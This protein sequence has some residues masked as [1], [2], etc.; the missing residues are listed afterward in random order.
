[1][2]SQPR[3]TLVAA[4]SSLSL[5]HGAARA[6]DAAV[7]Y[8]VTRGDTCAA[9][10]TR[11]YGDARL[12]DIIHE[13]N[14]GMGPPPHSLKPGRVLILPPKPAVAPDGPDA[15]LT[16]TKNV[17]EVSAPEPRSGKPN[18]PL[19]R[20]NRVGTKE[21]STADV[22]FRDETRLVLG[23]NTLVVILG[24]TQARAARLAAT[25][26][27]LVTGSLRARLSE[28][29]GKGARPRVATDSGAVALKAGEAQVS[30]DEKKTT[31]LAVYAGESALT[32]QRRSVDVADGFGSKAETGR[33]PTPPRPLPDAPAWSA[34]AP[35]LALTES[36]VDLVF[37]FAPA[38]S[39]AGPAAVEWHVQLAR[40]AEFDDL[41]VDTRVPASTRTIEARGAAAG[42]YF[43]RA[44]AIDDDRFEGKWSSVARA[45]V[46][47]LETTPLSGRRTRVA[48]A[49]S[50]VTCGVEG[51]APQEAFEIDRRVA[52]VVSCETAEGE[53]A[54]LALA[55]L[56][57]GRVD[58]AAE[59]V[60][61]AGRPTSLRVRLTDA[62]GSPVEGV[63]VAVEASPPG[64]LVGPF[65]PGGAGVFVAP[66]TLAPG[67]LGG[68]VRLR[69]DGETEVATNTLSLPAAE[70]A[71]P[72]A[73]AA[74][75]HLELTA[76]GRVARVLEQVGVG[77][78]LGARLAMPTRAGDVL[79]GAE[80]IFEAVPPATSE[81]DGLGD[82]RVRADVFGAWLPLGF[83]LGSA[84]SRLAPYVLV[85]PELL[86]T[87]GRV[88][89]ASAEVA[90]R[91]IA[92][93]AGAAAGLELRLDGRSALVF[94]LSGR[95][96]VEIEG[97]TKGPP[98][99]A[100]GAAFSLGYRFRP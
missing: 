80:G 71:A 78:S 83:R 48:V 56:P 18:D 82:T 95:Y 91:S 11:F 23:E 5:A 2:R 6:E 37:A 99:D 72:A 96:M 98:I 27:T 35:G 28:L 57:L 41:V 44:S 68:A 69:V 7:K 29:A 88:G 63:A 54:S 17:V 32:A 10:A 13:A 94:E 52:R 12:V 77:G 58:A 92:S 22:T 53:R 46:A 4:L 47:S 76:A 70:P 34:P 14:P 9:I 65:A 64:M 36:D 59:L 24:D 74:A 3:W 89:P 15:R 26:A 50:G 20:G 40:D 16:R 51:A 73:P 85:G 49:P 30:V 75:T 45:V 67:A 55:R 25:E 39:A 79:L 84:S 19:F 81:L 33:P 61:P 90:S 43:A 42:R 86:G 1:M 38:A 8:T 97:T 62:A 60:P 31:R 93:G 100:S 87:R 66:L 21:R